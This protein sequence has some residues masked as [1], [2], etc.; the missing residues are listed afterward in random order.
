LCQEIDAISA[1]SYISEKILLSKC[2]I[3]K[4][5]FFPK[6]LWQLI[7]EGIKVTGMEYDRA[8]QRNPGLGRIQKG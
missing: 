2:H 1:A 6:I 5:S 4:R 3:I 8:T 7:L